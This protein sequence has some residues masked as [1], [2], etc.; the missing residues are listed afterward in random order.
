MYCAQVVVEFD[1]V[2]ELLCGVFVE[3]LS[4]CHF[5]AETL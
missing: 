1:G 4:H 3:R 5:I 2:F